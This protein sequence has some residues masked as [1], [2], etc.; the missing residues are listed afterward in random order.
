MFV[1]GRHSSRLPVDQLILAV[2]WQPH[3]LVFGHAMSG[4]GSWLFGHHHD[5]SPAATLS[6]SGMETIIAGHRREPHRT[7]RSGRGGGEKEHNFSTGMATACL[8][9]VEEGCHRE[10]RPAD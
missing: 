6:H 9:S 4:R 7:A 3:E 1:S 10:L 5:R 8:F 2:V